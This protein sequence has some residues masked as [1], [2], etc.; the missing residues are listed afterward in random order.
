MENRTVVCIQK[1]NPL[2][3][4]NDHSVAHGGHDVI[5]LAHRYKNSKVCICGTFSFCLPFLDY[6][7]WVPRSKAC[8]HWSWLIQASGSTAQGP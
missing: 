6:R 8:R 4:C 2:G 5:C 1:S 7:S 3:I